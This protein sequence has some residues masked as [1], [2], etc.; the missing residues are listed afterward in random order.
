MK[1]QN[2]ND[3][4]SK[5]KEYKKLL[6]Y[7]SI[8]CYQGISHNHGSNWMKKVIYIVKGI[9][10]NN[11]TMNLYEANILDYQPVNENPEIS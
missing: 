3:N 7:D 6:A 2:P 8:K 9:I 4:S 1:H 10:L 11:L 5:G